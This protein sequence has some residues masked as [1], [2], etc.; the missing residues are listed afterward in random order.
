VPAR[1]A[2][3]AGR[4]AA[5]DGCQ[6]NASD[7]QVRLNRLDESAEPQALDV[8]FGAFGLRKKAVGGG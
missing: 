5:A 7:L 1:P 4:S 2:F 6:D 3:S 8:I